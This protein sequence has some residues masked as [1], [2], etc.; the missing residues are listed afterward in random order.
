MTFFNF[1]KL[2]IKNA[3][4]RFQMDAIFGKLLSVRP[5]GE[6]LY[7]SSSKQLV[8]HI[9][10]WSLNRPPDEIRVKEVAKYIARENRCDGLIH[11]A[12]CNGSFVVYDGQTRLAAMM[13]L[14]KDI[15]VFCEVTVFNTELELI[16]R[17]KVINKSV[18][19]PELYLEN[20]TERKE[21]AEWIVR[22]VKQEWTGVE[23]SSNNP[24]R[25]HYNRDHLT[26]AIGNFLKD[27]PGVTK[28]QI[29]NFLLQRNEMEKTK[30]QNG[31]TPNILK[32]M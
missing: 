20:D 5:T 29:W 11:I 14:E 3:N 12:A 6:R 32:Q 21:K 19:V 4:E 1:A 26:N 9:K 25:P 23:S 31:L 10:F 30:N 24:R 16:E 8:R 13:E 17:F 15:L 28:E 27:N 22:K 7:E 2:K 18:P